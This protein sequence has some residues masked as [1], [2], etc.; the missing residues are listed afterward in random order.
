MPKTARSPMPASYFEHVRRFPLVRIASDRQLGDALAAVD[1]LLALELDAGQ[2]A[3]LQAL[4]A[5][6]HD[7]EGERH[8]IPDATPAEVLR[9]LIDAN[10]LTGAAVAQRAGIAAST[11]SAILSGTRRPTPE[12][13]AA[14]AAVFNVGPAAFLPASVP[15]RPAKPRPTPRIVAPR[16]ESR[17]RAR[18]LDASRE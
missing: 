17:R 1:E 13:M 9:E 11:V 18:T 12:Q 2:E 14:L 3:Y 16:A 4:T 5:L 8:A 7:Y 15:A 10:G 6:I